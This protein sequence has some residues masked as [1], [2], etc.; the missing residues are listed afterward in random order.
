[1]PV[2]VQASK[3]LTDM[4][5][6]LHQLARD[7]QTADEQVATEQLNALKPA[8][9]RSAMTTLPTRGGLDKLVAASDLQVVRRRGQVTLRASNRRNI[10]RMNDQG[11]L[12]HPVYARSDRPRSQWRWVD[13]RIPTKWFDNPTLA[14]EM[15]L[16]RAVERNRQRIID[17][18]R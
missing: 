8:I 11:I 5:R 2:E 10:R 16:R 14:A 13:Q 7:M 3:E 6:Q 4:A 15:R 9:R 12:R 1:M 17:R 18:V